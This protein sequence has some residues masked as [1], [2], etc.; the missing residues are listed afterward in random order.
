M[1]RNEILRGEEEQWRLRSRALWL[2][3]GDKNSRYFHKFASFNRVR[4]HI[5]KINNGHGDIVTEQ[6]S[7]KEATVNFFKDF[8]KASTAPS[9]T[10]QCK[11]IEL[12]PQMINEEEAST[13]FTPVSLEELKVVLLLF[14]KEKI[15]G[16]DGWTVELFIFFF[17]L[18]GEDVLAMV[19]ESRSLGAITGGL[20][21]TFLTLIPKA[22]NPSSFDDFRPISLMQP[23]LQ[24]NFKNYC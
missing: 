1:E 14:K 16:L 21:S 3:S 7:I 10:E 24:N 6:E 2:T 19:E 18:V 23:L 8:Y 4:K 17:D 11:L 9:M 12:Y 22:N 20:N 13:L 15:L 5:W